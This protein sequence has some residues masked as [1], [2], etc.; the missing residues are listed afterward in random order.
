MNNIEI[1]SALRISDW[2]NNHIDSLKINK[3]NLTDL[4]NL[5]NFLIK[6][7]EKLDEIE[8]YFD[9]KSK[10]FKAIKCIQH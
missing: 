8:V 7:I 3:V 5:L 9:K 2:I 6:N 1:F 10:V 4:P